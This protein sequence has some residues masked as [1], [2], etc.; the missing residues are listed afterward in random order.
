MTSLGPYDR[1]RNFVQN[2]VPNL[3]LAAL[4]GMAAA[5]P[6]HAVTKI[7]VAE[8]APGL[9]RGKGPVCELMLVHQPSGH[10]RDVVQPL[11]AVPRT[12]PFGDAEQAIGDVPA[13]LPAAHGRSLRV[14]FD[15]LAAHRSDGAGECHSI[16][17][18]VVG[19]RFVVWSDHRGPTPLPRPI[20][21]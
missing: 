11:R 1:A 21:P 19:S 20:R 3:L 15:D 7:A 4:Q 12:L 8:A 6:D 16:A 18:A 10:P 2:G 17:Q 5:D 14:E 13:C 9:D